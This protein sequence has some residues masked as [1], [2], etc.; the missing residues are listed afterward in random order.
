MPNDLAGSRPAV[1]LLADDNDSD[2]ELARLGFK[3]TKLL[4]DLH[5]VKDGEECMA[6][7]RKQG[8]YIDAPTPDLLLLDINMPK[9]SGTQVLVEIVKDETLCRMPV[10][11]LTTSE[12][13]EE[14]LKLYKLRCSA[15]IVKP[16]DF[17][18]FLKVVRSIAEYWFTVVVLPKCRRSILATG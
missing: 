5:R 18:Q 7:L 13:D 12:D 3:R 2:V 8:E 6:F 16:I 17:D 15:C 1:V 9:M 11:I 4:L 10:V 14:I